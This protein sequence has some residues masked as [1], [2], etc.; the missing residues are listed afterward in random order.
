MPL[1]YGRFVTRRLV[2][3]ALWSAVF[4]LLALLA[5]ARPV[6]H[7]ES[8]YVAATVLALRG[9]PYRDFAYLQTPLQP[10]L[11]A[12]VAMLAGGGVWNALRLVNTALGVLTLLLVARA[13]SA[14]SESSTRSSALSPLAGT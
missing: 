9:L 11:F 5:L 14:L 2:P 4:L 12:P 6:D 1:F 13:K 3:V 10:L 7:D 8:K